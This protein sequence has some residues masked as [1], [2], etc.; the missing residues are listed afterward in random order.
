[1]DRVRSGARE[2]DVMSLDMT[3]AIQRDLDALRSPWGVRYP[4]DD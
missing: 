4:A 2:S 3:L 1:M